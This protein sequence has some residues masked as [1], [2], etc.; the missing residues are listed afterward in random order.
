M[1]RLPFVRVGQDGGQPRRL[2]AAQGSGIGPEIG[3]G[4]G[5]RSENAVAPVDRVEI[6]GEDA[7]LGPERFQQDGQ[8]GLEALADPAAGIAQEQGAGGLLAEGTGTPQRLVGM[9]LVLVHGLLD[10]GKVEAVMGAEILVL[11]PD[12]RP[13]QPGG[14]IVRPAVMGAFSRHQA[15]QHLWGAGNGQKTEEQQQQ[16]RSRDEK[17]E[18]EQQR[19]FPPAPAPARPARPDSLHRHVEPYQN[20]WRALWPHRLRNVRSGP[21]QAERPC[22]TSSSQSSWVSL[23]A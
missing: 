22:T 8:I 14:D 4:C 21:E 11:G 7:F 5:L 3:F 1:G 16:D 12:H 10:G 17:E 13:F 18:G 23:K 6:G 19:S 15:G 20:L 9:A 2:G